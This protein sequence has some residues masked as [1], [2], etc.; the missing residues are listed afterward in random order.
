M[1]IVGLLID[2]KAS[3]ISFYTFYCTSKDSVD[4]CSIAKLFA[5]AASPRG[6]IEASL[7]IDS[8]W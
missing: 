8:G 4:Y 2:W 1:V 7:L 5:T 3:A 6:V